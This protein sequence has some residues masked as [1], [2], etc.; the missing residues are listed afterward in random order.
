[1]NRKLHNHS[2]GNSGGKIKSQ[3]G[4]NLMDFFPLCLVKRLSPFKGN[5][6]ASWINQSDRNVSSFAKKV[7]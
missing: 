6:I 3:E 7:K 1:M 2:S 4:V 5:S